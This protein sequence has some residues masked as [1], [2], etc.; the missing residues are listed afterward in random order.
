MPRSALSILQKDWPALLLAG[1]LGLILSAQIL[2]RVFGVIPCPMCLWQRYIHMAL[3]V[4]AAISL[5]PKTHRLTL[6]TIGTLALAGWAIAAWQFAAQHGLLPWPPSCGS[7]SAQSLVAQA[8]DLLAAM[9]STKVVPCD[10]ETFTV[11]G[12]SLA[13]WN[14]P[15]MA[16][17]AALAATLFKKKKA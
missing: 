9:Q 5:S 2:T 8:D 12:L 6:P 1:M 14:M 11:L 7:T 16:A 15:I 17:T 10:K 4:L 13:G 3:A